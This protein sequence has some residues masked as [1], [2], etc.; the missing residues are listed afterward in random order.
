[1]R[2]LVVYLVVG[3]SF[4]AAQPASDGIEFF[5]K[6]IRPVLA[7]KCYGCHNSKMKAAMG[8]LRV[9]TSEGL[10]KGGDSGPALVAGDPVS[11]RLIQAVSY[12]HD[13]KMPPT[14]KLPDEQIADL[15]AW[16]KM[17]APDPRVTE[18]PPAVAKSGI[19]F[20]QARKFWAFQPVRN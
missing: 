7:G 11:S 12:K 5:E 6:K 16:V 13:V 8:G 10:R 9:D 1:M 17:G 15:E 20:T 19:D 2:A 18:P 3:V 4:A 14:G